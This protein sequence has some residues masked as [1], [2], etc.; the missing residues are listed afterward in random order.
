MSDEN[1]D[2]GAVEVP[3][4][5]LSSAA[6]EGIV[7]DLV[8]RDGTDYGASERSFEEKAAALLR[9]LEQG[10]A[11]LAFDRVTETIGLMTASELQRATR[12][13]NSP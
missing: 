12:T 10:E 8:T 9:Q 5:Q 11:K 4:M 7:A 6:L 2:E 1:T 13:R 3:Y